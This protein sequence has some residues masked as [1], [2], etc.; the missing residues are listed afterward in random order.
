VSQGS[1]STDQALTFAVVSGSPGAERHL[2]AICAELA[3]SLSR[4]VTPKLLNSYA[5]LLD[6][7]SAGGAHLAW[8]PPLVAIDME[9]LHLASLAVCC[10]R[11]GLT[12]YHAA[13]FTRHGSPI[14]KLADLKGSHIAWVDRHSAAG[15]R[16]PR[17]RI[18][19]E[20]LDPG[21]LFGKESFLGTHERVACAVLAGEADVGATYLSLDPSTRQRLSAG[22][23]EAGAGLN[24]A[25]VIATAGPIPAD[26]IVLSNR[27]GADAKTTITARLFALADAVPG[28]VGGLFRA[29]RFEAPQAEHFDELRALSAAFE[30]R[31]ASS[32]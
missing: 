18:A 24:G 17:M 27:L 5:A 11:S 6:E 19:S 31:A 28:A 10:S 3:R 32:A 25:H 9:L 16:V 14:D 2:A 29:D 13:L 7:V 20:G 1:P 12:G 30:P 15:Y 21:T 8:A 26:A 22:W 4:A 23:L